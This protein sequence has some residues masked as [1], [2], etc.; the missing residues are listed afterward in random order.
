VILRDMEGLPCGEIGRIMN[1]PVGSVKS[2][3]AR[4]REK[5]RKIIMR[6]LGVKNE[7]R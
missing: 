1:M 4:T 3:A 2:L 7:M 5:L 6:K